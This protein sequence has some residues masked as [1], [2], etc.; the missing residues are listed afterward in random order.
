LE[1]VPPSGGCAM[2]IDRLLMAL[3]GTETL[4]DILPFLD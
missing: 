1:R 2:G 4:D 3:T